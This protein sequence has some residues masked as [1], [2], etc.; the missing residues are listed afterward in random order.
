LIHGYA[1]I[2]HVRVWKIAQSSLP[3]LRATVKAL[4]QEFVP[5]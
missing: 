2:E 4:L 1:T 3:G 5:A